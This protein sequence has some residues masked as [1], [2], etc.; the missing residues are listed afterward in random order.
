MNITDV[1][2]AVLRFQYQ[3]AR[4]PLQLIEDR[5]VARL[6][7][8]APARLFYERSLGLLDTTVGNA[9]GAP[10]WEQ[11]GAALIERSDQLRRAARLDAAATENIKQAG[12]NVKVTRK[13]AAKER[14]DAHAEKVRDIQEARQDAQDRKRA[15]VESAEKR[16]A[17][18]RK[19]A[20]D[21]AAQRKGAV[22]AAKQQEEAEIRAAE[23]SVTAAADAQLKD[24]QKQRG[25]AVS[26]RAEADRI[27]ELADA[28][29]EQRQA[30]RED[31]P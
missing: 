21:A 30:E 3:L 17:A 19:R 15:A 12:S 23:R 2:F 25:A 13:K 28:E 29:K 20:D 4:F 31:E 7:S 9:L 24:A 8:E 27:E 18:G 5:V 16:T 22:E 6:D 26:K 10:E 1:P 14:E 11:R